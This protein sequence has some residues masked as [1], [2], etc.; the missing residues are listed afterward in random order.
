MEN[1]FIGIRKEGEKRQEG[2]F[3]TKD[4]NFEIFFFLIN[5]IFKQARKNIRPT[6]IIKNF[7]TY[8]PHFFNIVMKFPYRYNERRFVK[9]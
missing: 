8:T 3:P 2:E 4:R 7:K 6:C 5:M 1:R 9:N